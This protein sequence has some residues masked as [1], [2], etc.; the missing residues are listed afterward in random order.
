MDSH[1]TWLPTNSNPL[2][3][4]KFSAI[5]ERCEPQQSADIDHGIGHQHTDN[6]RISNDRI[7]SRQQVQPR[8]LP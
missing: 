5:P 7:A 6:Y 8:R 3:A 1:S 2:D 4:G